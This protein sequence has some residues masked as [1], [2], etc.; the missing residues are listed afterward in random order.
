M[1]KTERRLI[2]ALLIVGSIVTT[3]FQ[4]KQKDPISGIPDEV[5]FN[6]HVRPILV[7][8]CFLCHGPDPSSR[9]ANLRLDTY[10]GATAL[11]ESGY[12]AI[13]PGHANRSEVIQRVTNTDPELK[14]P[15]PE[16][17]LKLSEKDIKILKKWIDQG[18][19][20]KKHWAFIP[21]QK[22]IQDKFE[23]R[24]VSQTI[25]GFI[26][27]K[28]KERRLEKANQAS[29]E[30][31]IRRVSYILTGL[32][33]TIKMIDRFMADTSEAAYEN[34]VDHYLQSSGFGERWA[35]HWMDI[36]RYAETKGHEFDFEISGA[37]RY[38]D[39]L[40]RAFND[41]VPY[42]QFL[43]E[44][45]AGDMID[46]IR[47]N[48]ITGINESQIGT[49]FYT[50]GEGKHSPVDIKEEEATTIDNILD[51][52]S[53]AFQGLTVSCAK[54]HDHKFDPIPTADYYA[55]Y[56]VIESTRFS[57]MAANFTKEKEENLK[58]LEK[59]KKRLKEMSIGD[60]SFKNSSKENDDTTHEYSFL[61]DF[62]GSSL[63]QWKSDGVAF[64]QTTRMNTPVFSKS[65]KTI[66]YFDSGKASSSQYSKGIFGAL[67][68]PNF[69]ID[70]DFIGVKALGIKSTIRIIVDN[71]Q[72]I[73]NPI[74]G[75][76]DKKVSS[77]KWQEISFNV[78][79]WK[80][81]KAY[82]EIVPGYF[83]GSPNH[84]YKLPKDA[85]IDVQYAIAFDG[86]WPQK[87]DFRTAEIQND[88]LNNKQLNTLLR[89]GKLKNSIPESSHLLSQNEQLAKS[90]VD[91]SFFV[92][93][94]DGFGVNSPVFI[95][96]S[97]KEPSEENIPRGFLSAITTHHSFKSP[98]SGRHELA[99]T[100]LEDSNP[101]TS[102][103]MINRIWHHLFGRGIVET[104]DNFGLQGKLPSHPDLLDY[105]ALKFKE[106]NWSI[107]KMIKAIVM[108]ETFQRSVEG[109]EDAQ[110]KDPENLLLS[111]F[112]LRRLESEA[113]RD[114]LLAAAG[115]LNQKM[116]GPP[117][118]VHLTEF[119]QG[120][121]RPGNSG[122]LDGEGRRSIYQGVRRNFLQP[123]MLTFDRPIPF[124]TFGKRN[125]TN[126]PAQSLILMNDPFIIHQA[127]IMA[128]D[129]IDQTKQS[130]DKKL[131]YIYL[132]ALSRKPSEE[133]ITKAN[134]FLKQLAQTHGVE[135]SA[136]DT[137]L[138]IWKDF[139][140][141]VF[142]LKEFIYLI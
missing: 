72:L 34:M 106:E 8:N 94:N 109:S 122:P 126:V 62:R 51:V 46:S 101:L 83:S 29:K 98:G 45:I 7:Q 6:F 10:E 108:T 30:T 105:L 115:N 142:N 24:D 95:R 80:G 73:Q 99:N 78:S 49:A 128:K 64:G 76:L 65:G 66:K 1:N 50:F 119:M 125:V 103:V 48:K 52:T 93:V 5:D 59:L 71:F 130:R 121:G 70:S 96:G 79:A 114:G 111:H 129:V 39:Y 23:K 31:L 63:D 38:R 123:M 67:R 141:S 85:Y 43:K 9:K 4:C 60:I 44:H 140:H 82:I 41:D 16:S 32:P 117:V 87:V 102:R 138:N 88:Y 27:A 68:S 124:S 107:K 110:S 40:I 75:E 57:P 81:H 21:P 61:G 74:Y 33:P 36:V 137:D 11:L 22:E 77:S 56:G 14:M 91:S 118:P 55:L 42:D 19:E 84:T 97:Y 15:P 133:E 12:Q 132:K 26:S 37:W 104:V 25:D 13:N 120:R 127:E 69:V 17:N 28:L 35:R 131:E 92:G 134:E 20:W 89:N 113:I 58:T 54:C 3:M 100:M 136:I 139:C 112:P 135:S 53:K 86:D 18:A 90:L 116:F 2:V 47:W